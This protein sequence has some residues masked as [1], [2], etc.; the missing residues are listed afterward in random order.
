M[1]HQIDY[2]IASQSVL[3]SRRG[4]VVIVLVMVVVVIGL[5]LYNRPAHLY[6]VDPNGQ[7]W[8]A[9]VHQAL[10]IAGGSGCFVTVGPLE[11]L[12]GVGRIVSI[13]VTTGLRKGAASVLFLRATGGAESGLAYLSGYPPPPDSCSSPISGPWWQISPMNYLSMSCP[14]GYTFTGA[15]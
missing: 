9:D 1:K 3:R 2:P 12:P 10:L 8:K 4:W 11:K 14:R 5:T 15:G 13:C 7:A 6:A